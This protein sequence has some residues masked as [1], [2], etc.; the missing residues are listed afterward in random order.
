MAVVA[1]VVSCWRASVPVCSFLCVFLCCLFACE[2]LLLTCMRL[3]AT[4]SW[5]TVS[6]VRHRP[7]T[8]LALLCHHRHADSADSHL[9]V[10][11]VVL[12]LRESLSTMNCR[13]TV[14][15]SST[16]FTPR[17]AVEDKRGDKLSVSVA[18]KVEASRQLLAW[19]RADPACD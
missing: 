15:R 16:A 1:S 12:Q 9:G 11:L 2:G 8:S 14:R 5:S 6:P 18:R 10:S 3:Q 13:A 4:V 19:A 7:Q 17:H